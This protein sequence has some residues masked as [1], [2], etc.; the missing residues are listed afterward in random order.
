MVLS[1]SFRFGLSVIQ[2][3]RHQYILAE[4]QQASSAQEKSGSALNLDLAPNPGVDPPFCAVIDRATLAQH[5]PHLLLP[6]GHILRR[7]LTESLPY[8]KGEADETPPTDRYCWSKNHLCR[9]LEV[10]AGTRTHTCPYCPAFRSLRT[11]SASLVVPQRHREF[12]QTEKWVTTRRTRRG[13]PP[14]W[15]ATPAQQRRLGC[16]SGAR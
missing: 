6:V 14:R 9:C 8:G 15:D 16:R 1:R 4:E 7:E 13:G 5:T 11:S 2:L 10:G 12:R 3:V